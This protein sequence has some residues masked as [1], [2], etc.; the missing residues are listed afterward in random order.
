MLKEHIESLPAKR[1]KAHKR[2]SC[3][4]L[5]LKSKRRPSQ[6]RP[7]VAPVQS[8]VGGDGST[9]MTG[10]LSRGSVSSTRTIRSFDMNTPV[11]NSIHCG[12]TIVT[13]NPLA[14]AQLYTCTCTIYS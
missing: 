14:F 3:H 11:D 5:R 4:A 10:G 9:A 2:A 1:K 12:F 7:A 13:C 6:S 8:P